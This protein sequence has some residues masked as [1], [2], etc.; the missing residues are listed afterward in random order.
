MGADSGLA[1][2]YCTM[3][4]EEDGVW[5]GL[6][7]ER[8]GGRHKGAGGSLLDE[9]WQRPA[10]IAFHAPF[11]VHNF[12]ACGA[13]FTLRESRAGGGGFTL[14]QRLERG[15]KSLV[16]Q[17]DPTER[18]T[19]S[20]EVDGYKPSTSTTFRSSLRRGAA[21]KMQ[22]LGELLPELGSYSA[23]T[24]KVRMVDR[25]GRPLNVN[26]DTWEGVG[27]TFNML[28]FT[29]YWL[30][31]KTSQPLAFR[32]VVPTL[33][34]GMKLRP[35]HAG[36][37][38]LDA[39]DAD[40]ITLLEANASSGAPPRIGSPHDA[41]PYD[42]LEVT[43]GP[44]MISYTRPNWEWPFNNAAVK[45]QGESGWSRHFQLD[46]PH[47][48]SLDSTSTQGCYELS[49]VSRFAPQ[50]FH[51]T[52]LVFVCPRYVLVNETP[53][54]MQY[55]QEGCLPRQAKMLPAGEKHTFHWTARKCKQALRVRVLRP[56]DGSMWS[57]PFTIDKAGE[58][59]M[60]KARAPPSPTHTSARRTA[61]DA[62]DPRTPPLAPRPRRRCATPP[63]PRRSTSSSPCS[64][65]RPS[66][67][68]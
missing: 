19:L 57:S 21:H 6:H 14:T 67:S 18:V 60:V 2:Y 16:H 64:T 10:S 59:F 5:E 66:S 8:D 48:V 41:V 68:S 42:P 38:E 29:T 13:S 17:L 46:Q 49:T 26:I 11:A 33:A 47:S 54:D 37:T 58:Q 40:E 62:S 34:M 45:V 20:M 27:S 7:A 43:S 31:N 12:L 3:D 25:R 24:G 52:R 4:V 15:E 30:V 50:P 35:E 44:L 36:N 65:C 1:S 9:I 61:T 23:R 63:P 55:M 22:A 32:R 28:F 53:F 56:S 51:R 39:E